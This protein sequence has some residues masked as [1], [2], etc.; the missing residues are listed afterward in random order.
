MAVSTYTNGGTAS[1][2]FGSASGIK[3]IDAFVTTSF[4][5]QGSVDPQTGVAL[6]LVS[7]VKMY[8]GGTSGTS[9]AARLG[10]WNSSTSYYQVANQ[11]INGVTATVSSATVLEAATLNAVI[12]SGKSY[13][14]GGWASSSLASKR[15]TATGSFSSYTGNGQSGTVG[16]TYNPGNLYFQILYYYLPDA[17]GTPTVTSKTPNSAT[18]SWTAPAD[19]GGT[20]VTAYKVQYNDGSGWVTFQEGTYGTTTLSA[21]I[22]G[23]RSGQSYTFRVAA[24]NGV[25]PGYGFNGTNSEAGSY[26]DSSGAWVYDGYS[27]S[28]FSA[29]STSTKLPGGVWDGSAWVPFSLFRCQKGNQASG[30]LVMDSFT[31][32]AQLVLP[33]VSGINSGDYLNVTNSDTYYFDAALGYVSVVDY[34]NNIVYYYT[35]TFNYNPYSITGT[36]ATVRAWRSVIPKRY[37]GTSWVSA[38]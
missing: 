13:F 30:S 9:G 8:M 26:T 27:S 15:N 21:T 17:P 12:Q 4:P 24:K 20:P 18:I 11:T 33:D 7:Q 37:N 3:F 22:T 5:T 16:T 23:L 28:P 35:S 14:A 10:L 2:P 32:L 31:N 19:D 6:Y 36:F 38:Y 29:A 34:A 25:V 1:Q